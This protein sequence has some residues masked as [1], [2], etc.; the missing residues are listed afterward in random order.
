MP[1]PLV[2]LGCTQEA[3]SKEPR[4]YNNREKVKRE[5]FFPSK[6]INIEDLRA[7]NKNDIC[8]LDV[9]GRKQRA[10]KCHRRRRVELKLDGEDAGFHGTFSFLFMPL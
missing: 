5:I 2:P 7:P 3:K 4:G 6:K 8:T 1:C 10:K 9:Y